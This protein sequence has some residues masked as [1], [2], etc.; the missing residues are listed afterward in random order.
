[1]DTETF[2]RLTRLLGAART[3]RSALGA[4]LGAALLGESLTS[5]HAKGK[6][7]HR[8]HARRGSG[9]QKGN[10]KPR[11]V[12]AQAKCF[13]GKSCILGPGRNASGCD[14]ANSTGFRNANL[15]GSQLSKTNLRGVDA[16]GAN[17]T[18]AQL[19]GA[20]LV[21][22]NLRG[23]IINGT[24]QM[25]GAILCRTIMPDGATNNSGCTKATACC[26]TCLSLGQTGCKLGGGCCSGLTCTATSDGRGVC[27]CAAGLKQCADGTCKP[28]CAN[29]DC[30]NPTPICTNGQCV[31]CD[32]DQQ[33]G[34]GSLCCQ[35]GCRRGVCCGDEDCAPTGDF[36]T[37]QGSVPA[38]CQCGAEP[39]CTGGQ[40]CCPADGGSSEC[41]VTCGGTSGTSGN[42]SGT[43]GTSGTLAPRAPQGTSGT[44]APPGHR[45]LGHLGN[46]RYVR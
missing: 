41:R 37:R 1:M 20:C 31:A 43:S 46:F 27:R 32:S 12:Q 33:C 42:T 35:F 5:L 8:G 19:S 28:C 3:R 21:D 4:V 2:D 34:S 29:S 45:Q 17:F 14:F 10:G 23:A 22:A 24:T 7:K 9:K 18:G 15:T 44:L 36:C 26:Q 39:P 25:S 16:R 13:P 38:T 6:E 30:I 11:K 40:V